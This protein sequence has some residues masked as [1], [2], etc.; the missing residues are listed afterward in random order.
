MTKRFLI[1]LAE[2]VGATFVE[3]FCALLLVAYYK[4]GFSV[5]GVEAAL[6]GSAA[7]VLAVIKGYA[8]KLLGDKQDPSLVK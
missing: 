1:D 5:N 2:R 8:A 3:T 7:A 4:N 6:A